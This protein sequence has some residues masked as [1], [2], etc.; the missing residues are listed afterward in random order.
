MQELLSDEPRTWLERAMKK[1]LWGVFA[2]G[3]AENL[4][5]LNADRYLSIMNA[6]SPKHLCPGQEDGAELINSVEASRDHQA[7]GKPT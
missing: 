1:P 5:K 7:Q 2:N 4:R 3:T 6:K